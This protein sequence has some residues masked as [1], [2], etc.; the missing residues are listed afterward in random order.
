MGQ[1]PQQFQLVIR[2]TVNEVDERGY[3]KGYG[4]PGLTV[5]HTVTLGGLDFL[6]LAGVLGRFHDLAKEV[7][8]SQD[9]KEVLT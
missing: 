9:V 5:E 4:G 2:V 8:A 7:E 6:G 1:K 3:P